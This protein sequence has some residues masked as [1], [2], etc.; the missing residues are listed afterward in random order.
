LSAKKSY[1]FLPIM[2]RWNTQV[3]LFKLARKFIKIHI[4][5]IVGSE[6]LPAFKTYKPDKYSRYPADIFYLPGEKD[7]HKI[8]SE[9]FF[10]ISSFSIMAWQ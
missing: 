7:P 4:K 3:K 1:G 5:K 6:P 10:L 8:I 9:G 2:F